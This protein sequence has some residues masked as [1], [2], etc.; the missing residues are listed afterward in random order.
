MNAASYYSSD[1]VCLKSFSAIIILY[2]CCFDDGAR[3]VYH[4]VIAYFVL[5]T[6]IIRSHWIHYRH[7]CLTTNVHPS[8]ALQSYGVIIIVILQIHRHSTLCF[9]R[10]VCPAPCTTVDAIPE[11]VHYRVIVTM[12][13]ERVQQQLSQYVNARAL[14]PTACRVRVF[15]L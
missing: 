14:P 4:V 2:S 10:F 3:N 6:R 11:N 7:T 8:K 13:P 15:L 9:P 12:R 5:W 1:L